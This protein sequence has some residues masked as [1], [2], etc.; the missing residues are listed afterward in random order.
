MVTDLNSNVCTHRGALI[1][2]HKVRIEDKLDLMKEDLNLGAKMSKKS[3]GH[4]VAVPS[5][6]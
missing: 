1:S 6:V 5:F 2:W 3:R 4:V